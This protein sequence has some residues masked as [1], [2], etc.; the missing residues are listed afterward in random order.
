LNKSKQSN[1]IGKKESKLYSIKSH[2]FLL[3]LLFIYFYFYTRGS[4]G[5]G[6]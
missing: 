4:I 2:S 6:R 3:Y 1:E 5:F